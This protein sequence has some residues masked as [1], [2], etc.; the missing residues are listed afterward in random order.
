MG[1][2]NMI[3]FR[4]LAVKTPKEAFSLGMS[5]SRPLA[6]AAALALFAPPA[7]IAQARPPAPAPTAAS[8]HAAHHPPSDSA[9]AATQQRGRQVMGVDQYTST[10]VFEDLPDGGRIIL[11][12]DAADPVDE[13]TIRAHLRDIAKRFSAGDF[14]L[15][16]LVHDM[17]VPGTAVMA[18]R[19]RHIR[20]IALDLPRGGQVRIVTRD[21]EA[22][23]AIHEFLA[24]QRMDHRAAGHAPE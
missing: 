11:Q 21:R 8:G 13:R 2:S 7:I 6:A 3:S 12:R 17:E 10:H 16:G 24:F 22:L 14:A 18:R 4:Y 9:F 1:V 15:P 5:F 19:K 20:Y 23:K